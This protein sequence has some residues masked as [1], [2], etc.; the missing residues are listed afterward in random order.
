VLLLVRCFSLSTPDNQLISDGEGNGRVNL[1]AT[2]F[3]KKI[4]RRGLKPHGWTIN[5]NP[6]ELTGFDCILHKTGLD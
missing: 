4:V 5:K 2:I 6:V 1:F 3:Q